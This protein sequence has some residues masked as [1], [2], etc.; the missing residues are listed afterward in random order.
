MLKKLFSSNKAGIGNNSHG[1]LV[2]QD[3]TVDKL[4]VCNGTSELIRTMGEMQQYDVIQKIINDC[5]TAAKQ[6]HPLRPHFTAKYNNE[7]NRLVSTPETADAFEK[8][9]KTIK[10]TFRIDYKK[11]PYMEKCE[12][13]WDYAYRTQTNVELETTAYQ[14]YLGNIP[15]PFPNTTYKEGMTTI[16]GPPEFPPAVEAFVV[17]GDVRVP[18]L[19]RR[20]PCLE[21][22]KLVFGTEPNGCAFELS[23][24]P[25]KDEPKTDFK[26]TN[27][28][29]CDL[30]ARLEREKL[31]CEFYRTRNMS[32][33]IGEEILLDY[34]FD[35][36]ELNDGMFLN[37]PAIARYIECL[38]IIK[39]HMNCEFNSD[40]IS[41]EDYRLALVLAASLE[42]KWHREILDFDNDLRCAYDRIPDEINDFKNI[43]VEAPS[44]EVYLQGQL[45]SIEKLVVIY[46]GAKVNNINSVLKHK[47]K[48]KERILLTFRPV[49]GKVS[50][51]K[52]YRAENIQL[53]SV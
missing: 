39:K 34:A 44:L 31:Y 28:H 19:L 46:D 36:D 25:H 51:F 6:S 20:K 8:F 5:M 21:Y 23:I 33:M 48:R 17:S 18:I 42:G 3:S 30:N 2:V 9:P 7:L 27:L 32:V 41:E 26:I 14:E 11:Y 43:S 50:F 24:T 12:T 49:E 13:P 4:V 10:G 15:D 47:K 52:Y 35:K 29:N 1:N 53:K 16:I 38:L 45:F 40:D 37:A 22:G